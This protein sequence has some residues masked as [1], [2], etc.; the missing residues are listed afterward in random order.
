VRWKKRYRGDRGGGGGRSTGKC[1]WDVISE[2][3]K[4]V[5]A[6]KENKYKHQQK[7]KTN[8]QKPNTHKQ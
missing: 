1:G 7:Q 6:K 5:A 2:I 8:K 4:K 3:I